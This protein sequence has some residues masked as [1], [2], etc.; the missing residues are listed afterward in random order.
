VYQES[1][2]INEQ[3]RAVRAINYCS[4][5]S[6]TRATHVTCSKTLISSQFLIINRSIGTY[7]KNKSWTIKMDLKQFGPPLWSS[8]QSSWLQIQRSRV[9]FL[10]P[11]D[12][13][14]SSGSGTGS[15]QLR[16]DN[17]GA[18]WKDNSGSGLKTEINGRGDS[19]RWPL[20][21]LYPLKLVLT[22]PTSGGRSLGIVRWR[23]EAPKFVCCFLFVIGQK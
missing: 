16:Q 22:S 12:F 4:L 20:D 6:G 8:G 14:R 1:L 9:R 15:T 13:L 18:T 3:I 23:I 17:W 5:L 11:P 10:A 7:F 19:L 2:C 21:T